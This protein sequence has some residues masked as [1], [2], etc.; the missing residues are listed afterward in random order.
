MRRCDLPSWDFGRSYEKQSNIIDKINLITYFFTAVRWQVERENRKERYAH[1]RYD[2]VHRVE[3]CFPSH[4]Y[5]KRYVQV[6][7][8]AT[9]IDFLVPSKNKKKKQKKF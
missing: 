5:V 3:E 4:G 1:A 7:F 9:R 6:R 8:I 2:D